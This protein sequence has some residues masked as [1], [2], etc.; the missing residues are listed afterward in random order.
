MTFLKR[1]AL[2]LVTF[3][4]FPLGSLAA[5]T[6]VGSITSTVTGLLA[7]LISGALLGTVQWL[8]LRPRG[9]SPLWIA[10]TSVGMGVGS[11]LSAAITS[12][13]TS[14][15]DLVLRGLISGAVVGIAQ[16]FALRGRLVLLWPV[17]VSA[18]WALAWLI[19]SNVIVDKDR[20]YVTFGASGAITATAICGLVLYG[21]LRPDFRA[22]TPGPQSSSVPAGH[23][24]TGGAR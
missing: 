3:V 16:A 13:G 9:I 12:A 23:S 2:W 17:T 10:L 14:T 5:V 18:T 19:T 6:I 7:G 20:G 22:A 21:I 24:A 15:G 8:V 1:Y 4:G 11:G